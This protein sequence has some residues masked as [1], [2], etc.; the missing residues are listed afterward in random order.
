MNPEILRENSIPI[1]DVDNVGDAIEELDNVFTHMDCIAELT[2]QEAESKL[3]LI[4]AQMKPDYVQPYKKW[5]S[6]IPFVLYS[7]HPEYKKTTRLD[8]GYTSLS[9]EDGYLIV[10][11]SSDGT[12]TIP[13]Q[14]YL[15]ANWK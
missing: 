13:V 10:I 11:I 9:L 15:E 8:K 4:V 2:T 3:K 12:R 7:T 5:G 14:E 6:H 1:I